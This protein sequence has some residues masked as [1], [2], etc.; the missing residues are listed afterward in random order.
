MTVLASAKN[1]CMQSRDDND[2]QR[3]RKGASLERK[4][5]FGLAERKERGR[6]ALSLERIGGEQSCAQLL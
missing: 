5:H 1:V 6:A 4:T 2:K 3:A